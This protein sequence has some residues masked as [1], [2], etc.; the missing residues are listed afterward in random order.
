MPAGGDWVGAGHEAG[1]EVADED[2][3][4]FA[5]GDVVGLFAIGCGGEVR[6]ERRIG[7]VDLGE[8]A[9]AG[10]TRPVV[11]VGA[12]DGADAGDGVAGADAEGVEGVGGGEDV[13]VI[14]SGG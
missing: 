4:A 3:G 14:P 5:A 13:M 11:I 8:D 7:L 10:E 6:V 12:C 2:L 1:I 9:N